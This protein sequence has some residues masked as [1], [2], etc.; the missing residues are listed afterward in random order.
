MSAR[1]RRAMMVPT[2]RIFTDRRRAIKL[3]KVRIVP[4]GFTAQI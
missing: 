2:W 4:A 3:G 1:F